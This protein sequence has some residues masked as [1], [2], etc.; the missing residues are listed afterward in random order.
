M[1]PDQG[2]FAGWELGL[3]LG[4]GDLDLL[5]GC[6]VEFSGDSR[7]HLEAC[8]SMMEVEKW[9]KQRGHWDLLDAE[10]DISLFY[11]L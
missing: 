4:P 7:P 2:R 10:E 5:R 1:K 6:V 11:S 9:E 3:G 8:D